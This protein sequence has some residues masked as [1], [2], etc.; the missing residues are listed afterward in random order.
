MTDTHARAHTERGQGS[1][2]VGGA[3]GDEDACV[4]EVLTVP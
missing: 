2:R 4:G 3:L 1:G